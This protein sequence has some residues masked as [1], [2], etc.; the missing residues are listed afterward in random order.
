MI[1]L[2]YA[3]YFNNPDLS[4][5]KEI[6]EK[7]YDNLYGKK[8]TR[9]LN[10]LARSIA[11]HFEDK[12]FATYMGN[13]NSGKGVQYDDLKYAF[14]DYIK[15]FEMSNILHERATTTEQTSR[16][17]YWLLDYE[18]VRLAIGQETPPLD[19]NLKINRKLF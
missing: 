1:D 11:G 2:E 19:S 14:G 18:F 16:Q 5:T 6:K 3:D 4:L 10:F 12:N 8:C 13:R 17:M 15:P 7:I 9:G